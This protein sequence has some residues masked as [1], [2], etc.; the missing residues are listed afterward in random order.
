[1][2][3]ILTLAAVGVIIHLV[4]WGR[5]IIQNLPAQKAHTQV[6]SWTIKNPTRRITHSL[7]AL[8]NKGQIKYNDLAVKLTMR[9]TLILTFEI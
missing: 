4:H 5:Q 6:S 2:V 7:K 8:T 9:M 3:P 1:M